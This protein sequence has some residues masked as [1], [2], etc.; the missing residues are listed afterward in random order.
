MGAGY[1][2]KAKAGERAAEFEIYKDI[3][4]D[5]FGGVTAAQFT[6]DLRSAGAV[7]R[8]DVRIASYGGD[9]NDGFAIF[10]QLSQH[11][12][13]KVVHIDGVCASI[14]SVIAMAGD[15]IIIS[16]TGSVMVHEGW[17]IAAGN[18][19][20]LRA[21]ADQAEGMTTQMAAV[22]AARTKHPLA[23]IQEWMGADGGQVGTWF[24]DQEAV[25]NGFATSMAKSERIA[26]SARSVW[27]STM[28]SRIAQNISAARSEAAQPNPANDDVRASLASITERFASKRLAAIRGARA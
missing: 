7:D 5:W 17:T 11:K 16:D 13:R 27:L 8:I 2:F 28:H 26:A 10:Q 9:M 25:D 24:Y 4:G 1:R 12:A 22:Y 21:I 14:A 15:E 3:G 20:R 18:A 6:A 23:K 19:R